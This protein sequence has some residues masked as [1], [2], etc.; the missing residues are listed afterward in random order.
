MHYHTGNV[1]YDVVTNFQ[2]LIFLTKKKMIN[3]PTLVHQFVFHIYH[4]IPRC[5]THGR[6]PLTD[7]KKVA[8]VN[9]ILFHKNSQKYTLEKS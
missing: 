4:L 5:S 3:I 9:R 1:S 2:A 6:I 7:K 8:S